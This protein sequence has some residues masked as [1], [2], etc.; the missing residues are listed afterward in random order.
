MYRRCV[1]CTFYGSVDFLI[2]NEFMD[3]GGGGIE[4]VQYLFVLLRIPPLIPYYSIGH[5]KGWALK[6]MY[7][8]LPMYLFFY[9]VL[10]LTNTSKSITR[11][12]GRDGP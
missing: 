4:Y 2:V 6:L 8:K 5:W 12:I 1:L 3:G 9:M 10:G 11:A 7:I